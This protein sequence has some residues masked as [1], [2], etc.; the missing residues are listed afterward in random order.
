MKK[1]ALTILILL[2]YSSAFSQWVLLNSGSSVH[3]NAV[4]FIDVQTG[5]AA[6]LSGTILKT[7]N[8]GLNWIVLNTGSTVTLRSVYF[9]NSST[10]LV[11]GY[12]GTILKTTNGGDNWNVINSGTTSHLLGMSFYND[13]VGICAGN[14]G[15]I[16]YTT[17]GGINWLVG[18]Q[19]YMVTFHSAYMVNASTG[20]CVGVNTIFAPFVAKTVNGGANWA[21]STFYL[22][23]NEGTLRDLYF[24]DSEN[25]IAVSNLW[26][27][28]GAVS[29]TTNGGANWSTQIYSSA[30]YGVDFPVPT[31]GYAVGFSGYILKSTDNGNSWSQ[32][33][34]GTA[35]FLKGVDFVD[36]VNGY[37]VGEG[38]TI[39]KTTNGGVTSVP[40]NINELPSEFKLFQNY[41]N[42][43]NL[44]SKIKYQIAKLSYVKL[45][46][47]DAL[48]RKLETLVNKQLGPG[49]YEAEFSALGGGGDYPS[50]VYL[51]RLKTEDF[52]EVKKMLLIK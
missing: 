52:S 35:A 21:Y 27:G 30:L 41:P 38:G 1:F 12:S 39:L 22:N 18:T 3:L 47:Y 25:G 17:N 49:T 36:S 46:V 6:G 29:K 32:Q 28:P 15:T 19:G 50:G 13:T 4:H 2:F 34:S 42:P 43:F 10:G 16:L 33:I 40:K 48:G 9:F 11:C 7:T 45:E 8:S 31:T 24:F 14:S 37:A 44:I 51:Y 5:Y 20:Y 23:N 26:N